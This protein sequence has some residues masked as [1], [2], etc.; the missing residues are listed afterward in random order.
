MGDNGSHQ[1]EALSHFLSWE[2]KTKRESGW[3]KVW[4]LGRAWERPRHYG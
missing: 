2:P 3:G 4:E 1:L